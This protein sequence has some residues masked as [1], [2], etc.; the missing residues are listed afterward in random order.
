MSNVRL[1]SVHRQVRLAVGSALGNFLAR[2]TECSNARA[3]RLPASP[4]CEIIPVEDLRRDD[5]NFVHKGEVEIAD[6]EER[7]R[8]SVILTF[9]DRPTG[10][11][12]HPIRH[13]LARGLGASLIIILSPS[14]SSPNATSI[15]PA[16]LSFSS[17]DSR[18]GHSV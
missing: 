2:C 1:M 15:S 5:N 16:R 10:E 4:E 11:K 6:R 18:P 12:V 13:S 7:E 9:T 8:A 3:A 17:P 14:T